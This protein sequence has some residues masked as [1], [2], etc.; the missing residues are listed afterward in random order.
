LKFE[1]LVA[2][3]AFVGVAAMAV[4]VSA[5]GDTFWHLRAGEWIVEHRQAL[6]ADPFSLTRNGQPWEYPGWLAEVVLY[7]AYEVLGYAGL[8]LLTAG[9]VVLAFALL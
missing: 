2:A 3:I 7:G 4:R 1:R 8:N 9:S 6:D 5:D